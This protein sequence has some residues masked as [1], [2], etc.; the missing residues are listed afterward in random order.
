[1]QKRGAYLV[2]VTPDSQVLY[3]DSLRPVDPAL[4][5]GPP[6]MPGSSL[7]SFSLSLPDLPLRV[8]LSPRLTTLSP[9][10]QHL[11]VF[12]SL[13]RSLLNSAPA[14]PL[15]SFSI[16]AASSFGI[17]FV[18][19]HCLALT[20]YSVLGLSPAGAL[21]SLEIPLGLH[22]YMTPRPL[23]VCKHARLWML[24]Y[25]HARLCVFDCVTVRTCLRACYCV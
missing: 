22:M 3:R 18:S 23:G 5:R 16:S 17:L 14:L 10:S 11:L 12:S 8:I 7:C 19:L 6:A 9:R 4:L 20:S 24:Y 25:A 13:P 2:G 21:D 15:P 1:M